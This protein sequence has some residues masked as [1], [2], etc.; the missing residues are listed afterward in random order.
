MAFQLMI[1]QSIMIYLKHITKMSSIIKIHQI[2]FY[3]L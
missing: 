2:D 1:N 3:L